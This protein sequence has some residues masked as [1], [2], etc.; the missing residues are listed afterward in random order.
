MPC[1]SALRST[2]PRLPLG[3]GNVLAPCVFGL[4]LDTR[5]SA[6]RAATA[7]KFDHLLRFRTRCA[8]QPQSMCRNEIRGSAPEHPRIPAE[9]EST[10]AHRSA[11]RATQQSNSAQTPN[12]PP[13]RARATARGAGAL[14]GAAAP[15]ARGDPRRWRCVVSPQDNAALWLLPAA[16]LA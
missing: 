6:V 12:R 9:S 15:S 8:G 5:C 10:T 14:C 3:R 2:L 1:S 7:L 11:H 16:L 13:P 4:L